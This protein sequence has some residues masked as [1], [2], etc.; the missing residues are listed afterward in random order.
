M[1]LNMTKIAFRAQSVASLRQWL[2]SHDGEALMTTRYLPKRHEEMAGGSL[3]WIHEH[4]IVGRSPILGFAQR[5]D[6]RWSIRLEPKLVPVQTIPRRAHQGWRY[7][8]EK[9]APPDLA[10][11]IEEGDV[12]PPRL[13][14]ELAKLGLV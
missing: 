1:P 9:D 13:I 6:G 4:A 11:D 8:D 5:D 14:G 2:E 7:L 3:Y 12:L 10:G